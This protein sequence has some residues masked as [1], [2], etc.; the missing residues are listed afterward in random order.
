[1]LIRHFAIYLGFG[2][3]LY[4]GRR[5]FYQRETSAVSYSQADGYEKSCVSY[6]CICR[7]DGCPLRSH[8]YLHMCDG[9]KLFYVHVLVSF[10]LY[11][12][13]SIGEIRDGAIV[14]GMFVD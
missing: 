10:Q 2:Q 11:E 8:V 7:A 12:N 3:N 1:M 4:K 14:V 9:I 13:Y 5:S 6:C